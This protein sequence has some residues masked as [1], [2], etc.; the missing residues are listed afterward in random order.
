MIV[1]GAVAL[2]VLV[3][4]DALATRVRDR[5]VPQLSERIGRD[6]RVG[7]I[8]VRVLPPSVRIESCDRTSAQATAA[9]IQA[10]SRP[11]AN[12]ATAS[13]TAMARAQATT[14]AAPV[15]PCGLSSGRG[16]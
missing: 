16:G 8:D 11:R 14:V 12:P 10:A 1:L 15:T 6:I 4:S 3:D 5:V 7:A 9:S 13:G 2:L